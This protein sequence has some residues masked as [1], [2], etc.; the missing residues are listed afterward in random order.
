MDFSFTPEYEMIRRIVRGFV[1]KGASHIYKL[2]ITGVW[3]GVLVSVIHS[4][5][6]YHI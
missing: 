2:N 6:T 5:F 3:A 1:C 4:R